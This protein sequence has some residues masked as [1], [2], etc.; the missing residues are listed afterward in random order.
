[1]VGTSEEERCRRDAWQ[2]DKLKWGRQKLKTL[3]SSA[4]ALPAS[5]GTIYTHTFFINTSRCTALGL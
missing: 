5:V 4:V 1:V 2:K 3:N